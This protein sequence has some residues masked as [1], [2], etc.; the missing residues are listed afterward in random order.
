[1]KVAFV[2]SAASSRNLAPFNDPSWQ[3]WACSPDNAGKLPRIDLWFELH[4]D[5]DWPENQQWAGNY[6]PWL[7]Q[8]TFPIFAQ[9]RRFIP[10]AMVFPYEDLIRR[11]GCYFFT[12]TFAWMIAYAMEQGATE[13]GLFGMDMSTDEEYRKQRTAFHHFMVLAQ[14][15]GIK[16]LAPDESDVLQPPPLYGYTEATAMG[17]KMAIRRRELRG[18]IDALKMEMKKLKYSIRHLSG[19]YDDNDYMQSIWCGYQNHADDVRH[20]ERPGE[21]TSERKPNGSARNP[22]TQETISNG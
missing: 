3:I 14:A 7:R 4:A 1:M 19:A 5:L 9:D 18:R 12:S 17:R 22:Q 6:V 21:R 16:I 20:L 2:G 8:Q 11:Y 15:K 10:N 13:I